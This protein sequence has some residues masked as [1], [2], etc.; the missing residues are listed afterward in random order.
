MRRFL[1]TWITL[2]APACF[3]WTI[4]SPGVSGW[5]SPQVEVQYDFSLCNASERDLMEALDSAVEVWNGVEGSSLKL[6][7]ARDPLAT[8]PEEFSS[9]QAKRTPVVFCDPSFESRQ[10][11][12]AHSIPAATRTGSKE[13]HLVYTGVILNAETRS[14]ANIGELNGEKLA[15][16]LAHELGH[17]IGLGHS[18]D[19]SALMY[20]SL[21]GRSGRGL[22]EDDQEGVR[23]LYAR[24]ELVGG[25]FGCASVSPSGGKGFA[26]L[27]LFAFFGVFAGRAWL[28]K[29]KSI[30][31]SL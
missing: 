8:S 3:G 19:P 27:S 17:A 28:F 6:S 18:E 2:L 1:G 25:P 23:F 29:Q 11:L 15:I 21:E 12:N 16:V 26:W 7:R 24:N 31:P 5:S 13:G 14:H 20:F 10:S 9:R 22:S 30:R 4:A